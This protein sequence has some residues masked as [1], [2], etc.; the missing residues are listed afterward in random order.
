MWDSPEARQKL[1]QIKDLLHR[2]LERC[3]EVRAR[4][5]VADRVLMTGFGI[6]TLMT[7]TESFEIDRDF[8]NRIRVLAERWLK[9]DEQECSHMFGSV[10]MSLERLELIVRD[11]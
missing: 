1:E 5:S 7:C 11:L 9:A 8:K 6:E 2:T 10:V 4:G 3:K